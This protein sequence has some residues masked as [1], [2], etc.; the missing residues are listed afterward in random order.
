MTDGTQPENGEQQR[1][2]VTVPRISVAAVVLLAVGLACLIIAA[3]VNSYSRRV[4]ASKTQVLLGTEQLLSSMKDLETGE[5][6]FV[7]TGN[8]NYLQPYQSAEAHINGNFASISGAESQKAELSRAVQRKRTFAE[9][10]VAARQAGGF[11]QAAVLIRSG[12]D[13]ALMDDVRAISTQIQAAARTDIA[14]ADGIQAFWSPVLEASSVAALLL[15][16]CGILLLTLIRRRSERASAVLLGR[17]L[18]NAPIGLGLL[19]SNSLIRHV[20]PALAKI[21]DRASNQD[22]GKPLWELFPGLQSILEPPLHQVLNSGATVANVD[23]CVPAAVAGTTDRNL[24]VGFFPLPDAQ[25]DQA[26]GGAG[27]VV[28]DVTKERHAERR[29]RESEERFRALVENS[30]AVIFRTTP[31]GEMISGQPSWARFTGQSEAEYRRGGWVN[32][33]HPEDRQRSLTVWKAAVA[34]NSLYKVEYR[35]RRHDGEWRTVDVRALPMQEAT[36]VREWVGMGTDVT[37]QRAAEIQLSAAKDAAESANRAKSQFLANMSHELRTPLSAVIGYSELLEEEMEDAGEEG[38]LRDVRKIQSNARHLLSLINDVLDLSKIEADRMTT[39]AEDFEVKT[40]IEDIA[41]TMT[42][43]VE[44]KG[45]RLILEAGPELG[46]M[47]TDLVKLRQCLFNLIGNAAKFTDKG[48]ITLHVQR[49]GDDLQ[50]DVIDSGIGMTPEQVSKLFERFVQADDSTTRRFGGTGLG[51]AITRAFC[52]LLGGDIEVHSSYGAGSTFSL[53]LPAVLPNQQ[54]MP[55]EE[56]K[57]EDANKQVVLVIDDDAAQRELLTRFLEREGFAV[58][59]AADGRTG[60]DLARSLR[61]RAILLDVMMPQ[62]DGWSVLSAIK[63]DPDIEHTP[64]VMVTFVNEPGLGEH[65]GAAETV[66]KPVEWSRLKGVMERFRGEAGDIL[67]VDDDPDTRARLRYI[68][69]RDGWT[70]AEAGDGKEALDVVAHAPP[71]VILLDLT[72]PVM[73]GFTFL[74]QLRERPG[75]KDIP[76]VV[77]TARL[78]DPEERNRLKA[79]D[80]VLIKGETDM[81]ELAGELRALTPP[82]PAD[83]D[84][85]GHN[86]TVTLHHSLQ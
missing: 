7:I 72:M 81:R 20:N 33:V 9:Q 34:N 39:Y 30:A 85:G 69:E 65:L 68:L 40:L 52:K 66:L 32:A 31:E 63:A 41:N 44:Q 60:M 12:K 27:L 45:N 3:R 13:K 82:S 46:S 86:D 14:K 28:V 47:H 24:Q 80:R 53:R 10:V 75:C 64:V 50:F 16:F 37:E 6:G 49:E 15:A 25:N 5:R 29:M 61:P 78:L 11:D 8:Q 43:L 71:K 74:E 17:V 56:S 2:G 67:I 38:N 36:G 19:D 73:D 21:G 1:F 42:G 22:M 54:E 55:A 57:Q 18:E 4:I 79:A 84:R 83:A 76:V 23:V 77:Y 26:R 51:L 35:L 48:T 70:V 59:V 62:M 58:R